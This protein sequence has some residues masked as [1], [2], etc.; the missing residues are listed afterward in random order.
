MHPPPFLLSLV[1][2]PKLS[3]KVSSGMV[4]SI[5]VR[6]TVSGRKLACRRKGHFND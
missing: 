2:S 1:G 6:A 3:I 5:D 4:L